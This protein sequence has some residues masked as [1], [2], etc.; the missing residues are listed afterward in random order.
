MV[1]GLL[2]VAL[3]LITACSFPQGPR[4]VKPD[5][6][7]AV[8][9]RPTSTPTPEDLMSGRWFSIISETAS[10]EAGDLKID[11]KQMRF[12]TPERLLPDLTDAQLTKYGIAGAPSLIAVRI[13]VENLG[14]G[15][16]EF[17]PSGFGNVLA[18]GGV[19]TRPIFALTGETVSLS[20]GEKEGF[21]I[22]FPV[23]IDLD[24]VQEATFT[25]RGNSYTYS[26]LNVRGPL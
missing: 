2:A 11:I 9:V 25:V 23:T 16:V 14:T 4:L 26:D 18:V 13:N 8:V 20:P 21:L 15:A 10:L 19:E 7:T 17:N 12:S 6:P 5:E 24:N 1:K 3:I 22:L